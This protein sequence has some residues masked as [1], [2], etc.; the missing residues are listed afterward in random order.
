MKTAI[1]EA[2]RPVLLV[3]GKAAQTIGRSIAILWDDEQPTVRAVLDAMPL[4]ARAE[5]VFVLIPTNH[6]VLLHQ[7]PQLLIDHDVNG[8]IHTIESAPRALGRALLDQIHHLGADLL[9]FGAYVHNPLIELI[10]GGVTRY[11]VAHTDL[12]VLMRH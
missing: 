1:F 4:L 7:L 8:E 9:V 5:R 10:S 11:M 12:P 3:P 6:D 2:D